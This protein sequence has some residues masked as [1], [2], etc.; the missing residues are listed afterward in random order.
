MIKITLTRDELQ[1]KVA[2]HF[3][4]T[5]EKSPASVTIVNPQVVLEEGS[6][7]VGLI[8]EVEAKIPF[9]GSYKGSLGITGEP[10]LDKE[11]K[12]IFLLSPKVT[13]LEVPGLPE[14]WAG[15]LRTAAEMGLGLFLKTIPLME[16]AE[17][18]LKYR[19]IN[20]VKVENG[21]LLVGFGL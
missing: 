18:D 8:A 5:F 7:R 16:L 17:K 20:S 6:S 15:K 14:L 1:G 10:F 9:F 12:A 2:T 13:M 21:K 11:R 19:M 3:P 4:K